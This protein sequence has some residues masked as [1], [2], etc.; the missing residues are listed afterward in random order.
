MIDVAAANVTPDYVFLNT[1]S[2]HHVQ[3]V[4]DL[5]NYDVKHKGASI[6]YGDLYGQVGSNVNFVEQIDGNNCS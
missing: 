4:K 5:E 1:G 3:L 6:R 2:P